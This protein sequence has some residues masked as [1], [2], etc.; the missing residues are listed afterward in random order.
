MLRPFNPADLVGLLAL[1]ARAR[2]NLAWSRETLATGAS[3]TLPLGSLVGEWLPRRG[4]HTWLLSRRG[5]AVGVVSV[6]RRRGAGSW[7]IDRLQVA[8]GKQPACAEILESLNLTLGRAGA[9]RVFLRLAEGN[10]L[11]VAAAQAGFNQLLREELYVRPRGGSL[12]AEPVAV[13]GAVRR[14]AQ[15]ADDF[16]LFRLYNTIVP[17]PVRQAEG[18]VLREWQ[19][20]SEI[21]EGRPLEGAFVA[22][23]DGE[24]TGALT[25]SRGGNKKRIMDLLA[26]PEDRAA[27]EALIETAIATCGARNALMCLLPEYLWGMVPCLEEHGF[28]CRGNF[29]LYT[30]PVIA[31]VRKP[32]LLPVGA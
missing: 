19:G 13:N 11:E 5:L 8:R 23:R 31:R 32:G 26:Q 28:Q 17:A 14:R 24:L 18:L 25:V 21:S 9:E 27:V 3:R 7:E 20:S 29:D 12:S 1:Q 16:N 22:Q 6:R 10:G 30:R 4:R 15:E 2:P